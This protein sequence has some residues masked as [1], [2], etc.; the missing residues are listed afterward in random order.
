MG[1]TKKALLLL[2]IPLAIGFCMSVSSAAQ[3][4]SARDVADGVEI[5]LL[6]PT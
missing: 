3:T 1:V 6:T 5:V 4:R 2:A